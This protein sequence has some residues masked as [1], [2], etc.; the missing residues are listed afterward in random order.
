MPGKS[1]IEWT[2][3]VWNPVT[4]CTKVSAG[5]DF[6]Y[7][8]RFAERWRGVPGHPYEQGFDLKLWPDRLDI[9]L[10]WTKPR[11][12]FVNSM[13]DLFHADVPDEFIDA[14]FG[15]MAGAPWH[16]YQVLTK[17]PQRMLRYASDPETPRRVETMKHVALAG[18]LGERFADER[19]EP[20]TGFPG[21]YVSNL[22]VVYS[23]NGTADCIYCGASLGDRPRAKF[24]SDKCKASEYYH[25]KQGHTTRDHVSPSFSPLSPDTG[26]QGH[27]RVMMHVDGISS[28]RLVHRLVLEAFDR[29]ADEGEQGCHINGDPSVNALW[30]LR[31]G[32]QESNWDDSKR[33]GTKRRY[34]KLSEAD[35][36]GIRSRLASGDSAYAI[37]KDFPVSDTQIRNIARGSQW[38]P[39]Q[40]PIWPLPSVWLG[41][42]VENQQAAFRLDALVKTPAAVRF[43]SAEPLIGPLD[44]G[45][46]LRRPCSHCDGTGY[47]TFLDGRRA[48]CMC[49]LDGDHR[50]RF[51]ADVDWLIAGGES[52]PGHRPADV[53]WFRSLADQCQDAGV[54]FFMKQDSGARSGHQGRIPDDLWALKQMPE[55]AR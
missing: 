18:R 21:Y 17:R 20:I 50:E 6:C 54:S 3:A 24:C 25:R 41:T 44:L 45:K 12:I 11:R 5:C 29:N 47:V 49:G 42:S 8:A 55:V 33:H 48:A 19:M 7:A 13:S 27:T 46:W 22:G 28:R 1:K 35:V 40:S 34:S 53:A 16:V 4:G 9:P 43:V 30:N 38:I 15:V 32:T 39:N 31:W 52:G 2:D 23:T 51:Y 26:E 14:V 10:R 36:R 37:S